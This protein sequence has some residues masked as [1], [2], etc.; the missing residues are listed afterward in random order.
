MSATVIR[1]VPETGA[2][3]GGLR[4][5]SI[6]THVLDCFATSDELGPSQV[7]RQLGVAKSTAFQMLSALSAGGLL[8]RTHGGRYRLSL[9]LFD[10]GQL[11]LDRLPV[12]RLARPSLLALHE[13]VGEMVQLGIPANG[14]VIYVERVGNGGL[15]PE[16]SGEVMRKVGG[17]ASS[18]GR[19]M[20]AFDAQIARATLTLPRVKHT[21]FTITD[22]RRLA[23]VLAAGRANGYVRSAD[24]SAMG[25]T[26]VAAPVFGPHRR[27]VG[28]ISVVGTTSKI[29]GPRGDFISRSLIATTRRIS[30]VM[31]AHGEELP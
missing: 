4:S 19:A 29:C 6:A 8:E 28:A 17:Y 2:V 15:G 12:R 21:P 24:E 13:S 14:H 5:V 1:P 3:D 22:D 18:A 27:V 11:V 23:R 25:Y 16:V 9:R 31:T 30:Q 10:Y 20:A 7:A 26:S